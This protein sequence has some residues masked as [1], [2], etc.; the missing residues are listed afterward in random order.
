MAPIVEAKSLR[1]CYDQLVAVDDLSFS[2]ERGEVFGFVGP[3]GAGKTTTIKMLLGLVWPTSGQIKINHFDLHYDFEKAIAKVGAV[4]EYPAFYPYLS[5]MDNLNQSCHMYADA[6]RAR[7]HELVSLVGLSDRINDLVRKYSLGMKQRLGI[8]R[9]LIGSPKLLILDEPTNGLDPD[10][11]IEFRQVIKNI[12]SS[13]NISVMISG[14]ILAEL[15]K[16]CDRALLINQGQFVRLIDLKKNAGFQLIRIM[17]DQQEA[18]CQLLTASDV[19][20]V[21][22][23]D[24]DSILV[25]SEPQNV[26]DLLKMLMDHH[27]R[28][29]SILTENSHLESDYINLIRARRGDSHD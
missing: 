24:R 10:G 19:W 5:G 2:I 13:E 6:T 4:V 11:V 27:I 8:C 29:K 9:A 20:Q 14:H 23:Q 17:T 21:A 26:N 25:R 1:K 28:I 12:V 18:A 15:D 7:M 3:N 22:S 16:L